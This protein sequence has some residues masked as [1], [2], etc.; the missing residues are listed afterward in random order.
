M[1]YICYCCPI[2]PPVSAIIAVMSFIISNVPIVYA[3]APA[4]VPEFNEEP[5]SLPSTPTLSAWP[6]LEHEDIVSTRVNPMVQLLD[7]AQAEDRRQQ[8]KIIAN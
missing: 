1:A 8:T 3:C 7:I 4:D 6:Y 5:A 2:L